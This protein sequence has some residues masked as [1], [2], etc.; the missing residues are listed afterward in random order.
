[1]QAE[2]QPSNGPQDDWSMQAVWQ[3]NNG[4]QNGSLLVHETA[5]NG[6]RDRLTVHR[7]AHWGSMQAECVAITINETGQLQL[8]AGRVAAQ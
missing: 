7:T 2:W 3:P 4:A 5:I 6:Q 1:L 8:N